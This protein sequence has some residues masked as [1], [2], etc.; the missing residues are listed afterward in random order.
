MRRSSGHG[1]GGGG[2]VGGGVVPAASL[3]A[4]LCCLVA[5][6][7]GA[8]AQRPPLPPTYKTLSGDA[9]LIIAQGGFSG[10]LP[11]S[12]QGAYAF[13]VL[14]S[15]PDT[16]SWCNVQLTRDGVGICLRDIDMQN[17]TTVS[18]VYPAG[19][20]TY[21]I[22]GV[23][24]TGWFPMD[25]NMSELQ[26]VAL[27][28]DNYLRP[29]TSIV[30]EAH[31]AGLEVYAADFANDRVIPYNY[32]YD[33][34]EEYLSFVNSDHYRFS[35]D[36]VLSDHPITASEAI[37]C[38][39]NLNSTKVNHENP[40]VISHNGASGDFPDC[41]DLAY[42]NAINDGADVIDCPIQ[43]TSD[44]VLVCMS[45]V[46]L[47][48]TTNVEQTSFSSLISSVSEIQSTPGIFT[49]N[50]TW[51]DL[52]SSTLK[53]KI[54]SPLSSYI[55]T[56]NPRYTNQGKFMKLS[57]FLEIGKDKDLFGVMIIIENA[58]FMASSLGFD[59]VDKV[60]TA[61]SDAGYNNQTA[62]E[63]MIRSTD[64]A[65]LV[66][67]KQQKTKCKLVYTLRPGIGDAS[68][69]SLV[70]MKKFAHAVV[71]DRTSVFALS[72]AFI[73]RKNNL[74]N[75]LQS[76]GLDV[77]VQVFRNEFVSQPLDYFGDATV[78]INNYVQLVN[79]SGFITD[80]PKTV[81]RY[82][83]NS[84]TR[85]G[86]DIPIYMQ[87]IKVGSLA[88]LAKVPA[89]APMP[90]LN[91]SSVEEPPLPPVASK[92]TSGGVPTPVTS[93]NPGSGPSDA[94]TATVSTSVLLAMVSAALLV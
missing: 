73:I 58:A 71:V 76:A 31:N 65:V 15:A 39:V 41:T 54:S 12:S 67:L 20:K 27:T 87:Y 32:S 50:L 25:F 46:N 9:P 91:A 62:K 45:S 17:C 64:S 22:N 78:E 82:K 66:K 19:Q 61:L 14:A 28:S 83:E 72:G 21:V 47:I 90:T 57:D 68:P 44:G 94:H 7:S 84:C 4:L 2:G 55:L 5:L 53:P 49:F 1:G 80:F 92:N 88:Q 75:N 6:A 85:L 81:R 34:L 10:I 59:I 36:G 38:F 35:V 51:D 60:N 24:K 23:Q 16:S 52:N 70:D 63:V 29:H 40:L 43:V 56:R 79:A 74:V 18:M 3:A 37:G 77:Y 48:D 86:N 93:P 42:R 33:P 8:A 89:M 30:T 11:D 26:S 13:G 69:S